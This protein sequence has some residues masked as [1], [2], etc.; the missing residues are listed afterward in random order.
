MQGKQLFFSTS[1][2][3]T[4]PFVGHLVCLRRIEN[5]LSDSAPPHVE[6]QN[7]SE[8]MGFSQPVF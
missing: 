1:F 5:A 6:A 2:L 8:T 4:P 7:A 3:V